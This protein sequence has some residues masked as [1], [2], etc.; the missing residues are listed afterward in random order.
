MLAKERLMVMENTVGFGHI[1]RAM[2]LLEMV[3]AEENECN[4]AKVCYHQFLG[5]VFI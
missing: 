1:P 5:V 2:E 3:W 4:W